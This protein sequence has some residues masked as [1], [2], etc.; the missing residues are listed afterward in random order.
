MSERPRIRKRA[1]VGIVN[2]GRASWSASFARQAHTAAPLPS[3]G[4]LLNGVGRPFL[5]RCWSR[6]VP[7][8]QRA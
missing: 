5:A 6:A 3:T 1:R 2:R 7:R 8:A 4:A